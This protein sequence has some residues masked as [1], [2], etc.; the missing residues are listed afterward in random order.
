MKRKLYSYRV[1]Q[2]RKNVLTLSC[3]MDFVWKT[4]CFVLLEGS[5]PGFKS[6]GTISWAHV[7]FLFSFFFFL[8]SF[9]IKIYQG[10]ISGFRPIRLFKI[11]QE[12]MVAWTMFFLSNCSTYKYNLWCISQDIC[13]ISVRILNIEKK[14]I[15]YIQRY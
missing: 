6:Q 2:W 9:F 12:T 15:K 14:H 13:R 4:K 10:T 11:Y 8:F 7:Y 3:I 5:D 1:P